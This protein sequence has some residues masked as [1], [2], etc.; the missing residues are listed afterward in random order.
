MATKPAAKAAPS[1]TPAAKPAATPKAAPAA[2]AAPTK[3]AVPAVLKKPAGAVGSPMELLKAAASRGMQQLAKMPAGGSG[4]SFRGGKISIGGQAIGNELRII[5]LAPQYERSFYDRIFSPEDKS[6]PDCYSYDGEVPHEKAASPQAESCARCP[7]NEWGSGSNGKGKGCKE[8]MR[9]A[10]LRADG[11][12]DAG[13]IK[14]LPIL[15]AKFSVTNTQQV[16]PVLQKLYETAGHPAGVVCNLTCH[17]DEARQLANDLVPLEPIEQDWQESIVSR[18]A[19]A[20]ELVTQPYPEPE[21][22]APKRP[23]KPAQR[24]RK[25]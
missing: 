9:L 2:K 8:G 19:A 20:E 11:A 7:H 18:L 13:V 21:A 14:S 4:V 25:F 6:P 1:K 10:F 3:A 17:P 15:V 16:Q 5:A 22:N 12:L 23:Q 24:A